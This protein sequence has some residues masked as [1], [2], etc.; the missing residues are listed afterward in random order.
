[1]LCSSKSHV[2]CGEAKISIKIRKNYVQIRN[3]CQN[4]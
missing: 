3:L 2:L 1:M 4:N